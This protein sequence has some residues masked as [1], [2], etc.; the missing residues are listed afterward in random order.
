MERRLDMVDLREKNFLIKEGW[1]HLREQSP[2]TSR[3]EWISLYKEM[4]D[5]VEDARQAEILDMM[6]RRISGEE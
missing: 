3:E 2:S 6:Y 4:R 1:A 5:D